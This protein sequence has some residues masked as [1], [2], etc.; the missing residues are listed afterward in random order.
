M[1]HLKHQELWIGAGLG[2]LVFLFWIGI[3]LTPMLLL[4]GAVFL[5]YLFTQGKLGRNVEVAGSQ[6][7][8]RVDTGVRFD[9]IG[10]QEVAKREL[11]EALDFVRDQLTIQ[12]LGIRP[13][14]GIL[15][16]GPPGTGKTLLAKAAA[17]YTDSVF[18]SASGS[19]FVEM[20]AG[21]GA[22]RVRQLFNKARQLAKKSGKS[23]AIVF[24]D[25]IEVIAGK[26]GS[27]TSHLEY[28]QTLNQL[29][30]EMDGIKPDEEVKIVLIGASNRSDLL[31]S[32]ITRPGRF[33]RQVKVDL[34]DKEGRVHI[35]NIHAKGKPLADEVNLEDV[36]KDTFGFSGAH[37]ESLMNEA[38]IMAYRKSRNIIQMED[39]REAI[40]KVIMGEKLEHRPGPDELK[41]VAI[42]ETG[43]ALVSELLK[44]ESVA[45][46]TVIPRGKA[47]GFMRQ[48]QAQEQYLY[49]GEFLKNQVA[50]CLGGAMA[51][52]LIYGDWSTGAANDFEQATSI[53]KQL[54]VNGLSRL[55]IIR[56]DLAGKA[57]LHE[58]MTEILDEQKERVRGMLKERAGILQ[59]VTEVLLKQEKISGAWFREQLKSA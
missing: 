10:G 42:H 49:T 51:E 31:D 28:D 29:L 47:L 7:I 21:V 56:E 24:I 37:L 32:A 12:Q 45:T 20:Y 8:T 30:V 58:V 35:L 41:R 55:G 54:I 50:I 44:P 26:R 18:V 52:E 4:G 9:D 38:A 15:L 43:H 23:S 2:L 13:L 5:L 25:E 22:S 11:L 36:A 34:P 6:T 40:D 17:N 33:D 48:V 1:K 39:I 14:K 57:R 59:S 16:T 3:D 53:A 46:L 19:E 27:H